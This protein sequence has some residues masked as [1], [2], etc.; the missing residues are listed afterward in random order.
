MPLLVLKHCLKLLHHR[1]VNLYLLSTDSCDMMFTQTC[2]IPITN[3]TI[4]VEDSA[5]F[6][7]GSQN[8]STQST[9]LTSSCSTKHNRVRIR[10]IFPGW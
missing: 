5:Q 3:I 7:I 4:A 8:C 2:E 9:T 10:W 6:I 1:C